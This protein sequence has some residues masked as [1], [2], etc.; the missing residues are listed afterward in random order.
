[1]YYKYIFQKQH[2]IY[3]Y[4]SL[5]NVGFIDVA[6]GC[7]CTPTSMIPCLDASRYVFWDIAHPTEKSYKTITPPIIEDIKAKLA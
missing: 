4:N 1:M 5:E 6:N 2:N 3:S 7:C